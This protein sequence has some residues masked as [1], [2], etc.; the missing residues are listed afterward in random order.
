MDRSGM[1]RS[2]INRNV[3]PSYNLIGEW[4]KK[5]EMGAE[6]PGEDDSYYPPPP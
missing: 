4:G 1:R 2:L 6:K 5:V 3:G